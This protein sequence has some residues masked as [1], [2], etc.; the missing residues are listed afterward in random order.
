MIRCD[1]GGHGYQLLP[2]YNRRLDKMRCYTN[3]D[4]QLNYHIFDVM[5]LN[6]LNV[7]VLLCVVFL[8]KR[9]ITW[10]DGFS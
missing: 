10:R 4:Y 8:E 2:V 9:S 5:M 1:N 3:L 6:E 7:D